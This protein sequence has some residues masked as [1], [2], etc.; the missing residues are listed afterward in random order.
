MKPVCVQS[1]NEN[2]GAIDLVHMQ[3][4]FTECIR[5]TIKWYRKFI[6]H[7]VE[8]ASISA[9]YLYKTQNSKNIQCK[10]FSLQLIRKIISKYGNQKRIS[11]GR[12]STDSTLRLSARHFPSL[13]TASTEAAERKC[14]IYSHRTRREQSTQYT[15][16]QCEK[17]DVR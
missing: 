1:Y 13:S 17:C 12:P 9:L 8:M 5:K 10:E 2:K 6:F 14:H 15:R 3:L 11:V 16:Y 7:I 4:S